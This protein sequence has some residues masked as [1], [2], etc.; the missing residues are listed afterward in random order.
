M[1]KIRVL[2]LFLLPFS[3]FSQQL[4]GK[5]Y[6]QETTVKGATVFNTSQSIISHTNDNGDFIIRAAVNDTII[7][8]SLFHKQQTLQLKKE[9]FNEILVIEL[10]KV[11]NDLEE[12]VITNNPK[13]KEFVVKTYKDQVD[14]QIRNDKKENPHLYEPAPSSNGIDFIKIA[15][16]I[17]KLFKSKKV[18]NPP[19][20][21]AKYHELDSLFS[22]DPFFTHKLLTNELKIPD[23]YKPLFFDYCDAQNINRELLLKEKRFLLLDQLNTCSKAF[24][25][26]I[27]EYKKTELKE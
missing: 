3:M 17:G 9:H 12:V 22:N 27:S 14:T 11:L 7:F 24:L 1:F 6:D 21:T 10:K 13:E 20:V 26:M 8:Y 18:K 15:G 5:I 16:L 25:N 2:I 4:K 23:P 19:I